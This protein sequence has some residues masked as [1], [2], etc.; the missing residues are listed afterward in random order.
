MANDNHHHK[1]LHPKLSTAYC[2]FV[3]IAL[4]T[5][6]YVGKVSF[7][8]D[9]VIVTLATFAPRHF[10]NITMRVALGLTQKSPGSASGSKYRIGL[11]LS[12]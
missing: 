8:A 4:F 5:L 11:Y 12:I 6:Q 9:N 2:Y 3:W 7:P 10:A 1:W